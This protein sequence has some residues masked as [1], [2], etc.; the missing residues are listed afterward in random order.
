MRRENMLK[1]IPCF[2]DSTCDKVAGH[3]R[4]FIESWLGKMFLFLYLAGPVAFLPQVWKAW[5]APNIDALRTP[6]WP[7]FL[8]INVAGFIM[9]CHNGNWRMRLSSMI[10]STLILSI[11]IALLVR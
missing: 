11:N 2:V 7:L 5:T 4:S 6:T 9:L 3:T 1:L 8:L 10:Y